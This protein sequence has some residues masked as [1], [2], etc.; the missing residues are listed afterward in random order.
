MPARV[1]RRMMASVPSE[2]VTAGRI[3]CVQP[4]QVRSEVS[5]PSTSTVSPRPEEGRS[6]HST[7][8]RKIS[9]MPTQTP[10]REMPTSEPDMMTRLRGL[11]GFAPA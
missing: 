2:S 3:T 5:T 7:A 11:P 9:I 4:S 8:N 6:R 10:G 1:M